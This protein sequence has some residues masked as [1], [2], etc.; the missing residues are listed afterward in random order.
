M[1]AALEI[2]QERESEGWPGL[3]EQEARPGDRRCWG[4]KERMAAHGTGSY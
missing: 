1:Q 4:I 2:Q 3:M